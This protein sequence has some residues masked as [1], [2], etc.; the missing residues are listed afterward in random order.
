MPLTPAAVLPAL[1][2]G[3]AVLLV[4]RTAPS[5]RLRALV[6]PSAGRAVESTAGARPRSTVAGLAVPPARLLVAGGAALAASAGTLAEGPVLGLLAGT[7]ALVVGRVRE[8][9]R[10][11]KQRA[12]ERASLGEALV[13][14]AGE[15]RAG[16]PPSQALTASAGLAVGPSGAALGAAARAGPLGADPAAVL[17]T[18]AGDT[19]APEV[20]LGLAT[21][22]QV[23][24]GTGTSLAR[25]VT[26]L[27][28]SVADLQ[29]QR[30]EVEAELAGPR[31][32]SGLLAV[33]PLAGVGLAGALGAHPVHVL[34]H[35]PL[36]IGCLLA[37]LV[38]DVLGLWWTALLVRQAGGAP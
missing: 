18:A 11:R 34:L 21:C 1:L 38:L 8:R 31:A 35:T 7:G 24:A 4:G 36:G 32:T 28:A 23:C 30:R 5:G 2:A 29:E 37:A 27:A 22:W 33:L 17:R 25:A 19:A 16:R 12:R 14:L 6:G 3:T 13:V 20:L 26:V 10:R 9:Q 15:L